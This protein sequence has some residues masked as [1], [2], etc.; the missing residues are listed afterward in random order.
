MPAPGKLERLNL[1]KYLREK[2]KN[3][4][5]RLKLVCVCGKPLHKIKDW[6]ECYR[7]FKTICFHLKII[8]TDDM[9]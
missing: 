5:N 6:K 4:W 8:N 9:K 1:K 3:G 2:D 7:K